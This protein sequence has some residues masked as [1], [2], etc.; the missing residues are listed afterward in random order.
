MPTDVAARR[1]HV[2]WVMAVA[3]GTTAALVLA[4]VLEVDPAIQLQPH[5]TMDVRWT[6][7]SAFFF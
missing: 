3:R 4:C 6:L 2:H 7:V 1:V 5:Q